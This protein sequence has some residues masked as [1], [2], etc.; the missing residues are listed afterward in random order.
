VFLVIDDMQTSKRDMK[1]GDIGKLRNHIHKFGWIPAKDLWPA[2]GRLPE[3]TLR[4]GS[5]A[6]WEGSQTY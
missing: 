6:Y 2:D 5:G 3:K 1:M 4:S